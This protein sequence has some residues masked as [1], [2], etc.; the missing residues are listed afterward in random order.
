MQTYR[1]F[2]LGDDGHIRKA[3]VLDATQDDDAIEQSK[4]LLNGADVELWCGERVV[5]RLFHKDWTPPGA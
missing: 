5:V 3:I 2:I 4:A 1:A